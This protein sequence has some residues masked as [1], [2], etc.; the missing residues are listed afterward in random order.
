VIQ[1]VA[2]E[3]HTICL[4]QNGNAYSWG[5]GQEYQTGHKMST[6][7]IEPKQMNLKYFGNVPIR[8]IGAGDKFSFVVTAQMNKGV[9]E[10]NETDLWI[11][12]GGLNELKS[13]FVMKLKDLKMDIEYCDS[14]DWSVETVQKRHD[15]QSVSFEFEKYPN[16]R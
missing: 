1:I 3:N 2:G 5:H 14:Q 12:K 11:D 10:T 13:G 8:C 7:L 16:L 4:D 9:R 15:F 6:I